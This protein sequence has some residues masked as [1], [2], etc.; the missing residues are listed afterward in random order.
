MMCICKIVTPPNNNNNNNDNNN[1]NSNNDNNNRFNLLPLEF[2]SFHH[3]TYLHVKENS[4]TIKKSYVMLEAYF[5]A[6]EVDM[7]RQPVESNIDVQY[8]EDSQLDVFQDDTNV[9]AKILLECSTIHNPENNIR[10][11]SARIN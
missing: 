9:V 3:N 1:N 5:I 4:L 7:R 8:I 2:F 10:M 6:K 11:P